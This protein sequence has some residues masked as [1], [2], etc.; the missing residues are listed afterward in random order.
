MDVSRAIKLGIA[1]N[2][3]GH[4]EQA[5]EARDFT[6]VVAAAGLPKGLFPWHVPGAPGVLG[7]DP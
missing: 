3:A 4:L 6:H 2:M 5:G 7:V 1:G